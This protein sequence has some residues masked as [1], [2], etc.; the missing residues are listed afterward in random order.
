MTP[1]EAATA[2][3]QSFRQPPQA[4][5][6]WVRTEINKSTGEVQSVLMVSN[7]P[8]FQEPHVPNIFMGYHVRKHPWPSDP[9]EVIGVVS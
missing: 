5:S 2:L 8:A 6:V 9:R 4:H 1:A 7:N 3:I